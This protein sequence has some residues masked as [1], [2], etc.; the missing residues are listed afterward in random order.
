MSASDATL[1]LA[2]LATGHVAPLRTGPGRNQAPVWS[3]DSR[4]IAFSS[5]RNG[6]QNIY[7]I[8][9]NDAAEE[10]LLHQADLTFRAPSAWSGGPVDRQWIVVTQQEPEVNIWLLSPGSGE[11]QPYLTRPFPEAAGVIDPTG[12][13]MAY[14][15][16]ESG[17]AEINLQSFPEPGEKVPVTRQ[18]GVLPTWLPNGRL[19]FR[20][21]EQRSIWE[22]PLGRGSTPQPGEPRQLATFPAG[23]AWIEPLPDGRFLTIVRGSD[24]DVSVMLVRN[25]YQAGNN[26]MLT[27]SSR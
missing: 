17:R 20:G 1:W 3:P 27:L 2:N 11:M 9:I 19:L 4:Q 23:T 26:A 22:V 21:L 10:R 18:G 7:T 12:R 13:W 16:L 15:S 14:L 8:G 5:D 6:P 24:D 25:W